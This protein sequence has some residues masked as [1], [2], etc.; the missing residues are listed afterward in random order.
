MSYS[1]KIPVFRVV[2][3][4]LRH[5]NSIGGVFDI[6]PTGEFNTEHYTFSI[7]LYLNVHM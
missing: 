3:G 2:D 7:H 6:Y 5:S 4:F 1:Y